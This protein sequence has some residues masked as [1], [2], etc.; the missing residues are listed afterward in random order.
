MIR[1]YYADTSVLAKRHLN[2]I[3]STWFRGICLTRE[4]NIIVTARISIVEMYSAF[5][6]RKREKQLA[7]QA[8]ADITADI[9]VI[10]TNEY[11]FVELTDIVI[12]RARVLLESYA[13]RAYDA[14]Q[15]ASALF[16]NGALQA[17]GLPAL[18]FLAADERLLEAA[19]AEGLLVDNPNWHA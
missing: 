8:Y 9:A 14:V 3:G 19:K 2:E 18:T 13:L 6:R 11:Q 7:E 5:N 15:L 10:C 16:A 1:H 12:E 4:N 17:S